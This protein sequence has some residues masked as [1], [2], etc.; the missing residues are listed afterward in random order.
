MAREFSRSF[1]RSSKWKKC[2]QYIFNKYHGLCAEC[3][4]PGEEVHHIEWL[5]PENINDL[6]IALGEEN[7]I[8]LC[9]NCHANKHR[10]NKVTDNRL[11]FNEFGELIE[12]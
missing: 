10:T 12:K 7:L 5:T 11:M 9:K 8:L 2:R 6:D 3:N 4:N 1:Y